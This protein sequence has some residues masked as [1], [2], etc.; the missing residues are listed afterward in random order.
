MQADITDS[1]KS[2]VL[3]N[4]VDIQY[5][6]TLQPC[7]NLEDSYKKA[8]I[9]CNRFRNRYQLSKAFYAIEN[10]ETEGFHIHFLFST[11]KPLS[12]EHIKKEQI[13]FKGRYGNVFIEKVVN[14]TKMVEYVLKKQTIQESDVTFNVYESQVKIN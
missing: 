10:N 13:Y 12:S 1:L 2:F 5:H 4:I 7:Y 11:K 3:D 8:R 9:F 14:P 6:A